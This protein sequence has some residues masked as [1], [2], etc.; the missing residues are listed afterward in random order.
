MGRSGV[1]FRAG[2][3]SSAMVVG[4]PGVLVISWYICEVGKV[5]V[6]FPIV[7]IK[8]WEQQQYAGCLKSMGNG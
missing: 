1:S 3:G 8:R 7:G 4:V 5:L 2:T 6:L